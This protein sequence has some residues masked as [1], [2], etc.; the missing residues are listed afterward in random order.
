MSTQKNL[1]TLC[2]AAVFT[3]GLAACGGGGGGGGAPVTDMAPICPTTPDTEDER[4]GP[5]QEDIA[6]ATKAA[7]TKVTAIGTE[8]KQTTD[9]DG[10]DGGLGGS[11]LPLY[12]VTVSR[13]RDG[14]TVKIADS[15]DTRTTIPSSSQDAGPGW[16]AHHARSHDGTEQ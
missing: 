14:T 5:R 6:A 13:D 9:A 2:F 10:M 16:W 3:L 7:A 12:S 11:A 15:A 1:I 4:T 8:A